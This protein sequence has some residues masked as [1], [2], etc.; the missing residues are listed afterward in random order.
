MKSR[1]AQVIAVTALLLAPLWLGQTA[2]QAQG[3]RPDRPVEIIVPTGAG[4]TNDVMARLIQ[5]TFQATKLVTTP[6][7][8]LNKAGGN[9]NL[10]T[11]H[12]VQNKGNP[13]VLLYS[14]ATI[15][16]NEIAG[17]TKDKYTDLTP[18]A[19]LLVD[20]SV[21]TVKADSPLKSMRELVAR[22]KADPGSISFGLVSR[23]GPN[24]LALAQAI[25]AA[26]LDP[27]ALRLVV[28][29]T[30]AESMTALIG[31]HIQAVV[32]SVSA[33]LPQVEAG[34]TR[35]VGIAAPRRQSGKLAQ[36]PTMR[37]EGMN[38][39]GIANWRGILGA[40]GISS[41]QAAFWS[42]ALAKAVVTDEWKK[43]LEENSVA[44][45]F[46]SGE[47]FRK[48]LAEAYEDTRSVMSDLGLVAK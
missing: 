19:L 38:A 46:I 32:S 7:V 9:Q 45:E 4:G 23:G 31:G 25:R 1:H 47:A 24:H 12:L 17:L 28:F 26:G 27:K 42:N 8:V 2:A 35:M 34:Q 20:Y 6:I 11:V 33:V 21:V 18:I 13:H 10:A 15:F 48:W 29:K 43:Q 22:L 41:A 5:Q 36:V 40:G 3:W 16:T 37:E 44:S 30:N 39:T 14:T